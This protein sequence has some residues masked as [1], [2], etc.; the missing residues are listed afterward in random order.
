MVT[1]TATGTATITVD[2]AGN[3]TVAATFAGLSS[4]ATLAHIHGPASAT[5]TADPFT[6]VP[7]AVT[8]AQA[9]TVTGNG[10][11]TAQQRAQLI[12][13]MTYINIH[14]VNHPTGEIRAQIQ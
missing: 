9:G 3:V 7:L 12:S 8:M 11:V 2:T 14:S 5:E 10:M 1:T 4:N 6:T 13:G